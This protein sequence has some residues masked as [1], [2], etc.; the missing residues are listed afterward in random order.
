[1]EDQYTNFEF[2][3][4]PEL[5]ADEPTGDN[6]V[7][8][9]MFIDLNDQNRLIYKVY[10]TKKE[11]KKS[12]PMELGLLIV[13]SSKIELINEKNQTM[14]EN[15]NTFKTKVF[16]KDQQISIGLFEIDIEKQMPVSG[17]KLNLFEFFNNLPVEKPPKNSIDKSLEKN[18]NKISIP[19]KSLVLDPEKKIYVE[20]SLTKKLRDYQKEGIKFMYECISG[21]RNPNEFGCILA[22]SMGLGKTLTTLA[23]IYTLIRKDAPYPSFIKKVLIITPATLVENWGNEINKWFN[24]KFNYKLYDSKNKQKQSL[25]ND[26]IKGYNQVLIISYDSLNNL[27]GKLDKVCDLIV[28]DEAHRLKNH[29]TISY[30]T[31]DRIQTKRKIIL[32]GTP[33]QN[34]VQEFYNCV[35]LVNNRVL[36]S[37]NVFKE[38]YV[39]PIMKAQN[40]ECDDEEKEEARSKSIEIWKRTEKFILRRTCELISCDLP[41]RHEYL[42]FLPL[43][44]LQD[45][46]YR[47]YLTTD[48]AD[49]LEYSKDIFSLITALKKIANHPDLIFKRGSSENSLIKEYEKALKLF[50]EDYLRY[51]DRKEFSNKFKFVIELVSLSI[52]N[53]EKIILASYW[54]KILDLLENALKLESFKYFRL[55]G[56]STVSGRLSTINEFNESKE[57]GVL[58]LSCKAGGTG[59]NIIGA[60]RMVIIDADWNPKNDQQAMARIWRSGQKKEVHIYR[61]V[62]YGTIEEKIYQRQL[63]KESLSLHVIDKGLLTPTMHKFLRQI[64]EYPQEIDTYSQ[65]DNP[66]DLENSWLSELS[67]YFTIVKEVEAE[68]EKVKKEELIF[69]EPN[70]CIVSDEIDWSAYNSKKRKSSGLNSPK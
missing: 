48:I 3:N 42:V 33:L 27:K 12:S 2:F 65:G 4:D 29:N 36:G 20:A 47:S 11:E 43:L 57:P 28:C 31:I 26:F 5:Y 55:D 50:P 1:M 59:L 61:L 63:S 22:D 17:K 49:K 68:W 14:L 21:I 41:P 34:Y 69:E 38:N 58:L 32:T 52:E 39:N 66:S 37:W 7:G 18:I 51:K 62:S 25:V 10:Y 60:S 64:F 46:L 16:Q 8:P 13:T 40:E 53:N 6:T 54:K 19:Y 44:P 30:K 9:E 15:R 23:L 45:E 56:S 70:S 67:E 24:K 35:N